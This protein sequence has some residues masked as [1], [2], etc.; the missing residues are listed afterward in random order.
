MARITTYS[1]DTT[2][3]SSDK[4]VGTD[5]NVGANFGKTKNYTVAEL[6]THVLE[7]VVTPD[8]QD[9]TDAG[10][11]TNTPIN[12]QSD[13]QVGLTVIGAKKGIVGENSEDF[14]SEGIGVS[15]T[16]VSGIGVYG[17]SDDDYG[18]KA[19]CGA[20]GLG[21]IYASSA[22]KPGGGS[23][24]AFSDSRIKE[25][26]TPY[27]KGLNELLQVNTVNYDYNGKGGIPRSSGYIGVIAQEI[28]DIFPETV[29]TY[30]ALL[31]EYDEEE[32]SLYRFDPSSLIYALINA[33]KEL[34]A[35]IEL[36]KQ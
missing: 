8:L 35:E 29:T 13:S 25:N 18:V 36:L 28:K 16:S 21:G 5:G 15:G 31:N 14:G 20:S 2:V 1:T 11:T 3:S 24:S 6:T 32:T 4:V 7:Q 19:I 12:I 30:E 22:V 10:N 34:K 17:Y 9:V 27:V 26:V 23:W 33:V